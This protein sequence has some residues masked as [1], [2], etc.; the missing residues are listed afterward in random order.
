MIPAEANG[1]YSGHH[2]LERQDTVSVHVETE[3]LWGVSQA[4][5]GQPILMVTPMRWSWSARGPISL[6]KHTLD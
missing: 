3:Y 2:Y 4:T 5:G 6:L 1:D